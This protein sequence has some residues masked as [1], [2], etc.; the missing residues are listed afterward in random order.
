M[1]PQLRPYRVTSNM[2]DFIQRS[3]RSIQLPLGCKDL[4]DVAE[5]QNWK[6]GTGHNQP[7]ISTDKLAYVEGYLAATLD[8]LGGHVLVGIHVFQGRSYIHLLPDPA[9]AAPVLFASW[10]GAAQEQALRTALND[11]GLEPAPE[12]VGRWKARQTLKY[13]LPADSSLAAKLIGQLFRTGYGLSDLAEVSIWSH[14]PK[15]A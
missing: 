2:S 14:D 4:F 13:L 6:P 3:D 11:A 12:A 9:L 1:V 10:N 8:S 5:I 15:P 7:K